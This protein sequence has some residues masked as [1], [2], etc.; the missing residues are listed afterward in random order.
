MRIYQ[1]VKKKFYLNSPIKNNLDKIRYETSPH[2]FN[3]LFNRK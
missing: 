1:K 3:W 2:H